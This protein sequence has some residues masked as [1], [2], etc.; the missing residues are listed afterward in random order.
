MQAYLTKPITTEGEAKEFFNALHGRGLLFHPDDSPGDVVNVYTGKPTFTPAE[1]SH[2]A[3]R[4]KEVRAVMSDPCA[5]LLTL[6]GE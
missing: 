1:C 2:V 4:I 5:Y 6:T 3:Q